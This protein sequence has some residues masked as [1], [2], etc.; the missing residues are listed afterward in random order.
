MAQLV[1]TFAAW[2]LLLLG[3]ECVFIS[4]VSPA[5]LVLGAGAAALGA[6]AAALLSRLERPR[7]GPLTRFAPAVAAWPGTLLADTGRLL[8]LAAACAVLGRRPRGSFRQV[9]LRDGAGAAWSGLLISATPGGCVVG[10]EERGDVTVL[11][12]HRIFPEPSALDRVLTGPAPEPA[13]G[14][15]AGD[16]P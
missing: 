10:V 6:A 12:V 8:R 11:T 2:W 4:T 3:L 16:G 15:G 9:R 13:P 14:T 7:V 1:T 5:E